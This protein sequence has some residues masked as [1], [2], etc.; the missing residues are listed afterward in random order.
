MSNP[1]L[2]ITSISEENNYIRIDGNIQEPKSETSEEIPTMKSIGE[3]SASVGESLLNPIE[4]I[5]ENRLITSYYPKKSTSFNIEQ[6]AQVTGK[7]TIY[8]NYFV[9]SNHMGVGTIRVSELMV[10]NITQGAKGEAFTSATFTAFMTSN[11]GI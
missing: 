9:I 4:A 6:E 8:T 11:T 1:T 10:G 2:T 3:E 7:G 5:S